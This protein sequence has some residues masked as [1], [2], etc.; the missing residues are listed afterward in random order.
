MGLR[1]DGD[2]NRRAMALAA[3]QGM[4]EASVALFDRELRYVL[5]AGQAVST[6]GFDAPALEGRLISDVLPPER[7]AMWEPIYRAA[8]NGESKSL[9]VA[10]P[11]GQ[12]SYR[13]DVGPWGDGEIAGGLVVA[14]DITER[15]RLE[16]NA[17]HLAAVVESSVDAIISK[18]I[19]GTILSWNPGAERLYGYSEAEAIGRSVEMLVPDGRKDEVSGLLA[20]VAS[21]ERIDNFEAV[22]VRRDGT[23]VDVMLTLS[24]LRDR[25]GSVIGVSTIARDITG[26]KAAESA[27]A[28]AR[29]DIDRF[30]GL[31]LDLMVIVSVEG[32]FIRVNPAVVE[33]LGYS[34]EELAGRRFMDF[35]HPDDVQM[36]LDTFASQ[37]AGASVVALENR[38]RCKDGSYRWLLWSAT[39]VEDGMTFATALDV[40]E[41]KQMEDDL[42]ASREQA[43]EASR[44]KSEFV[45][46]MSHEIRTPLNGV[47]S[48]AEL[49]LDTKLNAE[50]REYAQ[51]AL[52]SAE[53]LMRVINDILDFSKI[54]AGKLE[55]V[56]EDFSVRAALE[57]VAEIVGVNAAERGLE[58][59]VEVDPEVADVIRGDGNRVRQ[60][61]INLLSNAV[62]FT[63]EGSVTLTVGLEDATG[64]S[65][66]LRLDVQD[67]GIGIDPERLLGLF[68]PFA[69]GDATTTR[70]YGGTGLGLC[71]SKQL[72][73][74]MG[75]QIA[76][77]S[78]PGE[79]SRFWFTLPYEPGAGFGADAVGS[80]LTGTRV[81]IVD[82]VAAERQLLE[83]RVASWGISPDSAGDFLSAL[84][85]LRRAAEAGRPF[86]AALLDG[87]MA[88]MD[89]L[90]LAR[91]IKAVPA[92]R[93]TRLI[94]ITS[95]PVPPTE[96]E[97]AG[98][99]AQLIKPVRQSRLYNQLLTTLHRARGGRSP[100]ARPPQP[101]VPAAATAAGTCPVLLAE[102]NEV[103]QFAAIR[104]LQTLGF[105]VDV[106]ANGREAIT[107]SGRKQYAAVFMDCQMPEVDGYTATRVI[108]RREQG[109]EERTPIIALTA[110][111]LEGDRQKCL[112]SGMDD[113]VAKPLRLQTIQALIERIPGLRPVTRTAP[114]PGASDGLFD[115]APLG[116]IGDPQTESTL[117]TM[118][119]EQA[120]QRLPKLM[121]AIENADGEALHSLAH[122][123][124]GSAATIGATKISEL[125]RKLCELSQRPIT[126]AAV[127]VHTELADVLGR[128]GDALAAYVDAAQASR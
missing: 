121:T 111:A 62:K 66:R 28:Q 68:Q 27:L 53:A 114:P 82:Q 42:R 9:E 73:E 93:S 24:A 89:G 15:K 92:L 1:P 23:L 102:D 106:A 64:S 77:E 17:S 25:D 120:S 100:I 14:R 48:M 104:L 116:E 117:V 41:R 4:P 32:R 71:I 33:T 49:L 37:A 12:R 84:R 54:E 46:N 75:G 63:T 125:S 98:I 20:R 101:A 10:G 11:D 69:Q 103:N 122:G 30:F 85:L 3:L 57:D 65:Q 97:S 34:P 59:T 13:I 31:A 70:R 36:T 5:V 91:T 52:T 86:E 72:V 61:L 87:D 56:D 128:T 7:W 83:S 55:I 110:H 99:E 113:Y 126:P 26:A 67:T 39:S 108:R 80:D 29:K 22:R 74:L 2:E 6:E 50:Q 47:V 76:C 16:S 123:L 60:V 19:D 40:T 107:M 79:G 43:L 8:L 78:A 119:M 44:L 18:T 96:A 127:A 109:K 124:K 88:G 90:E 94:L 58:L 105:S 51:V 112:D 95:S 35:L 45:A 115:P 38:Y 21:G 81:L 118:F